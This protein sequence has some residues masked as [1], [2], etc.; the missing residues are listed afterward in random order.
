MPSVPSASDR[1]AQ[2]AGGQRSK[3]LAA[4]AVNA[5]DA[6][7]LVPT[8]RDARSRGHANIA[9]KTRSI[10]HPAW[11]G[12]AV[13]GAPR[14]PTAPGQQHQGL[15]Q[16]LRFRHGS[17]LHGKRRQPGSAMVCTAARRTRRLTNGLKDLKPGLPCASG[18]GPVPDLAGTGRGR[19]GST[20]ARHSSGVMRI[21]APITGRC[22]V[23]CVLQRRASRCCR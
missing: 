13:S 12:A 22:S 7:R 17:G 14:A 15:R 10:W 6:E 20:A 5:V 2:L 8:R 1:Q 23:H 18:C 21:P 4:Q 19:R 16:A 9:T 3:K 11:P